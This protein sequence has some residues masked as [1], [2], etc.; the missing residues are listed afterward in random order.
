MIY[1][2]QWWGELS[3]SALGVHKF[4]MNF[5]ENDFV[6]MSGM[7]DLLIVSSGSCGLNLLWLKFFLGRFGA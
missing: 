7:K 3:R 1:T 6:K 5:G 2:L 4:R